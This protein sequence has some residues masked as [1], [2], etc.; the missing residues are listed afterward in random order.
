MVAWAGLSAVD[1]M[2]QF[3]RFAGGHE[4][5][6]LRT[7]ADALVARGVTVTDAPYWRAYK[8]TF[9]A[10]EHVKVASNDF[11]RIDEYQRLANAQG[12]KLRRLSEQPCDG[13]EGIAAGWYLCGGR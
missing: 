12:D 13:G 8:I 10:R 11:S 6:T 4:P 7:L 1:H 9:L 5:N 2:Q 3:G